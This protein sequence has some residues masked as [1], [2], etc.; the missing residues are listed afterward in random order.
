MY[1]LRIDGKV[2]RCITVML[3]G[4]TERPTEDRGLHLRRRLYLL[5]PLSLVCELPRNLHHRLRLRSVCECVCVCIDVHPNL[6]SGACRRMQTTLSQWLMFCLGP[7]VVVVVS[8][9][10]GC[11]GGPWNGC[12]SLFCDRLQL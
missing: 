3:P 10:D 2:T 7:L 12:N 6:Y 1:Q 8:Q 11:N 9:G 4:R 5:L